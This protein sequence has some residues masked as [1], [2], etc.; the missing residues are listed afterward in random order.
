MEYKIQRL[1]IALLKN[2][3]DNSELS[4]EQKSLIT[5]ET[6]QQLYKFSL[7]H[8]MAHMVGYSLQKQGFLGES[9]YK[10]AFEKQIMLA[11]FR[12]ENMENE[13][14]VLV[15]L[16]EEEKIDFILLKG[17]VIKELYP[18]KW[19]RTCCDTDILVREKD[20]ER[21]GK[22][23]VEKLRYTEKGRS[24]HDISFSSP[25]GVS[26]ELHFDLL[27]ADMYAG[28]DQL[29]SQVWAGACPC[30]GFVHKMYMTD[31]MMYY[32]HIVHMSK[33]F[34]HGGCGVRPFV[35]LWLM[36][37][38]SDENRKKII[39]EGGLSSFE[40]TV[41]RIT[42][43]WFENGVH[44]ELSLAT[45]EYVLFGGV[46]GNYE[47]RVY[48]QQGKQGGKIRYLLSRTF[49]PME[50][51]KQRY[52]KVRKYPILAPVY[53]FERMVAMVRKKRVGKVLREIKINANISKDKVKSGADLMKKLGL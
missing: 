33:H 34:G 52:P 44:N 7:K 49:M 40:E 6:L 51:L 4:E 53:Q 20:V 24:A 47:N 22:L 17:A 29:L 27:E 45:E 23:L 12:S 21:T 31:E 13:I 36:K 37:S 9:K 14:S 32:Y 43:V 2:A 38:D 1:M 26:I 42:A 25:S 10:N 50:S 5:E 15:K 28:V 3:V 46:Y 35:D 30:E 41:Q 18:E 19:M 16:F 39:S 11:V 8:D 48:S